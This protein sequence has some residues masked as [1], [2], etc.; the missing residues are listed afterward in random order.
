[1]KPAASK[2]PRTEVT[3]VSAVLYRM[4]DRVGSLFSRKAAQ[5][6]EHWANLGRTLEALPTVN[7]QQVRSALRAE[8]DFEA[9]T[10]EERALHLAHLAEIE[11]GRTAPPAHQTE[12][13]PLYTR[14]NGK[15]LRVYPDGRRVRVLDPLKSRK[16]TRRR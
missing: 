9:L 15:L 7:L 14:E 3:R 2:A 16:K 6:I 8:L 12:D 4:A 10:T 13:V 5:Q 1:M 11:A